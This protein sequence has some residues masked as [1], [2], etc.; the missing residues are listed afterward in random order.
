MREYEFISAYIEGLPGSVRYNPDYP[1]ALRE[2][3]GVNKVRPLAQ[4]SN[5]LIP[6]ELKDFYVFSYGASL[7]EYSILTVNE[8]ASL[9]REMEATYE[10]A[11]IDTMLPFAYVRDLGNAIVFDLSEKDSRGRYSIKDAF[12]EWDPPQWKRICYGMKVWLCEMVQNDFRQF[13]LESSTC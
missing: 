4:A 8:I 5:M 9:T 1:Y 2:G 3:L 13:W 10:E 6:S 12:H 7:G 11:W